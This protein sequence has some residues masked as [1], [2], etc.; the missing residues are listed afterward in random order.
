MAGP[1]PVRH[2]DCAAWQRR[3]AWASPVKTMVWLDCPAQCGL[4]TIHFLLLFATVSSTHCN[5]GK[6]G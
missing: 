5:A 6:N 3:C 1:G 2:S 4:A